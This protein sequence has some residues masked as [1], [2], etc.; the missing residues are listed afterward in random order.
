MLNG[1]KCNRLEIFD[2]SLLE[3][4]DKGYLSKKIF[5]SLYNINSKFHMYYQRRKFQK[6]ILW[7]IS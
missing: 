5:F 1:A 3:L 7:T 4:I 6:K 2:T